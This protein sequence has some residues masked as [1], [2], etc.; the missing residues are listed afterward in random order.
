MQE[1]KNEFIF[2]HRS[3]KKNSPLTFAHTEKSLNQCLGRFWVQ[4][5]IWV[6]NTYY[7]A[8]CQG[9]IFCMAVWGWKQLENDFLHYLRSEVCRK[10]KTSSF[11]EHRSHKKKFTPDFCSHWKILKSVPRAILSPNTD[12]VLNT[13]YAAH[14]QGKIFCMAVWGW[15]QLE[16]DFLHYLRSEVCR[17][18]KTSSFSNTEAIKKIHPWLLLTLKNP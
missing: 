5:L 10:S 4:T 7:A 17:K 16:N 9:K 1:I 15:K 12:L 13:Y 3:H 2:E 6:L 18:S 8:H 14:C 11:F